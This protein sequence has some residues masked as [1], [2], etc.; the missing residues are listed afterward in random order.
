[1]KPCAEFLRVMSLLF[2]RIV[3]SCHPIYVYSSS[4]CMNKEISSQANLKILSPPQP[5]HTTPAG[6]LSPSCLGLH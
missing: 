1:M 2:G 5:Y 6:C 3:E 4:L